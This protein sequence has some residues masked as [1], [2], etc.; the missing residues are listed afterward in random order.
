V[1]RRIWADNFK[2]LNN[3]ELDLGAF[4]VLVGPNASGKTNILHAIRFL[5][6]AASFPFGLADAVKRFGGQHSIIGQHK[7]L[8]ITLGVEL[9]VGPLL[10]YLGN[11]AI[12]ETDVRFPLKYSLTF[13]F[14]DNSPKIVSEEL[15]EIDAKGVPQTLFKSRV[16]ATGVVRVLPNTKL[17]VPSELGVFSDQVLLITYPLLQ[18]MMAAGALRSIQ[19]VDFEP[20][21]VRLGGFGGSKGNPLFSGESLASLLQ[22]LDDAAHVSVRE[23]MRR[24]VPGFSDFQVLGQGDDLRIVIDEERAIGLPATSVSDGTLFLLAIYA[25][26]YG[27]EAPPLLCIEEPERLI[28]PS[29]IETIVEYLRTFGEWKQVLVTTHSPDFVSNCSPSELVLLEK[30]DGNTVGMRVQDE[31]RVQGYLKEWTLGDLWQ[32]ELLPTSEVAGA[33]RIGSS[34]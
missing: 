20:S 26:Y 25:F 19:Y 6:E 12:G 5:Q 2:S 30:R 8:P 23:A 21:A 9:E 24:D 17:S 29:L 14:K 32:R 27:G 10:E 33:Q 16:D 18:S 13:A 22:Q 11:G 7:D 1:I 4:T 31:K 15:A 34:R 28:H 3:F